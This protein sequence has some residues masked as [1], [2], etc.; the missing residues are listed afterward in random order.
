MQV[1]N[2]SILVCII[3]RRNIAVEK[4]EKESLQHRNIAV[5]GFLQRRNIAVDQRRN[6]A[7]DNSLW[8]GEK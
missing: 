2:N 3:I 4:N 8:G 5:E 6:I 1:Q 7:V